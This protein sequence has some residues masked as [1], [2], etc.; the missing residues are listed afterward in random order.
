[1]AGN[2]FGTIF[3]LTTFGE[4]H[5]EAIGGIVDGCPAGMELDIEAIQTEL[6]RRRPGNNSLG[7][8]RTESDTVHI[9]S[10]LM[11]GVTLGTPIGFVINN[12]DRRSKDYDAL[13]TIFRPGHA[14][15]TWEAKYGVRDHR[16]GGRSSARETAT[17]V[18]GGSIARQ[19]LS[20]VG[21]EVFGYVSQVKDVVLSIPASQ[22]DMD[23]RFMNEIRCPDAGTAQRMVHVI[24]EAREQ[25]DSVGGCISGLVK[26][27]P[28]GLG[29]PVF[30]KLHADLG[31]ALFSINA[32]KGVE[33]GAGFAGAERFGSENNDPLETTVSGI[34][35]VS[36]NSGGVLGGI[37]SGDDLTFRVAFKPVS[38]IGKS[39]QTVDSTGNEVTLE[40]KGRHD[41]C[42]LPRAVP[43]VEAMI[44]MVLC[45]H[46]LRN[47]AARI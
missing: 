24:E 3:R 7:T 27:L 30:D 32:V 16:G 33:F 10:G 22:L 1:M 42:V 4:S 39:Q 35:G 47:R 19:V 2:T 15:M 20:S 18:V 41:P 34:R 17:R 11:D 23:L 40:A 28:A 36:N 14:D 9:L 25:Q 12:R 44:C 43:I 21:A 38:T 45:D 5:G 6:D 46:L 37:S 26:G 31:K 8:E 29:E 13:K